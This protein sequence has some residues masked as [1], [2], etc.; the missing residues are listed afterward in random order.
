LATAR[1]GST[2]VASCAEQPRYIKAP[3]RAFVR[4]SG[5]STGMITFAKIED[6]ASTFPG[7]SVS[8]SYGT[9][10][11]KVG[12]KLLLRL[13]QKEDAIVL[14]LSSVEEQRQLID[15]D[16]M[17]FYITDHYEGYAAVLVRPTIEESTFNTFFENGW[18]RLARKSDVAEYDRRR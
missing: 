6:L 18:R 14:L 8:T 4:L 9:P 10:A 5:D 11:I 15:S 16:P 12:K 3:G 2:A 1:L 13:H 17:A 7:T